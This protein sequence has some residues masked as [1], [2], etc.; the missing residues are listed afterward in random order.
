LDIKQ[1][2]TFICVAETGSLSA[3]SDR[4]RLAQPALSRQIKLL[5]HKTGAQLFHRTVKGMTLTESGEKLLSRVSG[6]IRQLEQAV[7]EVRSSSE[8]ITGNVAIGL[9]PSINSVLAVRLIEKVKSELPQVTLRIVE[10][11]SGHLIE[12]LHRGDLDISFLYGPAHDLHLRC[13]GL[14]YENIALISAP[15]KLNNL[16]KE[17]QLSDISHLPIV[18]PSRPHGIRIL[19][20]NAVA[21]AGVKLNVEISGDAF[22]VL[23]SLVKTGNYHAFIPL[24][25]VNEDIRE[26]TLEART[27]ISPTIKRQLVLAMAPDRKNT[28]AA[29]ATLKIITSEIEKMVGEGIWSAELDAG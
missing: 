17:I 4:L 18:L 8:S 29:Q 22:E 3:A 24:S 28:R 23:K 27:F 2:K 7:D 14:L 9:M 1:L 13:T 10:G 25:A 5:E 16:G 21:K 20:D 12:W 15:G 19:V 6:I 26:G 11:Y